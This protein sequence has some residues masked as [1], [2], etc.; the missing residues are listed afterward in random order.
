MVSTRYCTPRTDS[1]SVFLVVDDEAD[2]TA[3]AVTYLEKLGKKVYTAANGHDALEI[4]RAHKDGIDTVILDFLMPDMN[5]IRLRQ[6]IALIGDVDAWLTS[7]YT[8]G[9][10]T[11][12]ANR[13][14]LT[15]FI[16][17]PFIFA[18]FESLFGGNGKKN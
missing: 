14:I 13:E 6:A 10:I 3:L 12:P 4:F 15:G 9:E 17:K 2:I 8:R 1:P 7:G 18:D 16:A 5:G 11:D